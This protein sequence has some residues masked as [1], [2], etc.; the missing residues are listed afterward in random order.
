MSRRLIGSSLMAYT[1]RQMM[2]LHL[3]N[4]GPSGGMGA[5]LR[6]DPGS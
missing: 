5:P 1:D 2:R 4:S 3:R 6:R